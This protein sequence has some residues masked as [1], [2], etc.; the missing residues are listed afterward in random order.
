M[1]LFQIIALAVLA[2]FSALT[3]AAAARSRRPAAALWLVVWIAAGAAVIVPNATT[4]IANLLGIER[5]ADLVFY[6]AVLGGLIGFF[7]FFLRLRALNRQV[8]LLARHIALAHPLP[9]QE[10]EAAP[11]AAPGGGE[12]SDHETPAG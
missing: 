12:K 8:T 4:R 10:P 2:L 3:V 9:P 5:G 11:G 6:A 7:L 1:S